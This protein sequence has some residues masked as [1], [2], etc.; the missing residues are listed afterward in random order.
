MIKILVDSASDINLKEAQELGIDLISMTINF[1]DEEFL[2]GVDLTNKEFFEKLIESDTMPKTSQINQIAF[3]ERFEELTSDGGEVIAIILSSK[4]SNTYDN[5]QKASEKF[6]GK[7]SVIDSLQACIGERILCNYAMELVKENKL[8]FQEITEEL[9]TERHKI[10]L[11]AVLG[12][13]EYLKKGGRISSVVAFAGELLSIKPVITL[14]NGQVK[15]IGKAMGSKKGN[16]LLNQLVEKCGG[17]NFDKPYALG[18]SGLNDNFLQKYLVDSK[19]LW[20]DK[21]EQNNIPS[22]MIGSTI[23]THIG[24]DAIAVAFFAK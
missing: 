9:N 23:G 3:E 18:F 24:P 10:K 7:V 15:L 16:N 8:S 21:V 17:I 6:K 22:F 19:N 20:E 14:E 2:D 5:A 13:L 12:T 11:L 1:D 4:L